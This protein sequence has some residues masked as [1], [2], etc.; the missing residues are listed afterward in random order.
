[1]TTTTTAPFVYRILVDGDFYHVGYDGNFFATEAEA[2]AGIE[3]L[4]E[5]TGW[6]MSDATVV[7]VPVSKLTP[8]D[9]R[10]ARDCGC[11]V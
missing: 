3:H 10:S 6:D 8:N 4:A 11:N 7:E 5:T 1:M 2:D 9:L